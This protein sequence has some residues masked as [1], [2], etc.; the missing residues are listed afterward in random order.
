[1][2]VELFGGLREMGEVVTLIVLK[3]DEDCCWRYFHVMLLRLLRGGVCWCA[4]KKHV[5]ES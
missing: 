5:R 3:G 2:N 1:M 4:R